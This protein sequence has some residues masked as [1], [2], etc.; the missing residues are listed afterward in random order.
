MKTKRIGKWFVFAGLLLIAAALS[1]TLYNLNEQTKAARA[2]MNAL[3]KMEV[4]N[5][6]AEGESE[7]PEYLR[8]P[9]MEMPEME[10][11]GEMYV[12][13][14]TI[15]TLEL[16]LPVISQWSYPRLKL[17]PCRMQGSAYLDDLIIMAHNYASHFGTLVNLQLG[18][19]IYFGD[20][21]GNIFY[22][23]VVEIETLDA[24]AVEDMTAGDWD[25]TLFTCTVGGK[26]RVTVRCVQVKAE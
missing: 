10:I 23:E 26:S 14:V 20:I 11:D 8:N 3:Q 13:I 22:Y 17:A 16:Q 21:E 18:D 12:G 4:P 5:E 6:Y 1:L 7:I 2:A 24:G 25:L 9:T 15:P 19:T